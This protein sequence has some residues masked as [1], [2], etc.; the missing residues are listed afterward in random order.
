VDAAIFVA[1]T[2]KEKSIMTT[3]PLKRAQR[4]YKSGIWGTVVAAICCFTPVLVVGLG[5]MGLATVTPYLDIVLFP[6]LGLFLILAAYGW[7]RVKKCRE[8]S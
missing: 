6:L 7:W 5:F 8:A 3:G 4:C 2:I 1:G